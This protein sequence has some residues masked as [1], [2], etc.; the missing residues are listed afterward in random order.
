MGEQNVGCDASLNGIPPQVPLRAQAG[1]PCTVTV[2]FRNSACGGCVHSQQ[3]PQRKTKRG[4]GK[5]CG[6]SA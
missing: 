2:L 1:T 3:Q 5:T 4:N 6:I